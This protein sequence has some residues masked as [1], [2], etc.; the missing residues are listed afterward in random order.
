MVMSETELG[1]PGRRY[2]QPIQACRQEGQTSLFTSLKHKTRHK[3]CKLGAA[4]TFRE[5]L[6]RLLQ[7]LKSWSPKQ[8]SCLCPNTQELPSYN[9][10]E[11]KGKVGYC[12]LP[13]CPAPNTS[14]ERSSPQASN[15]SSWQNMALVKSRYRH[16]L[17]LTD[18]PVLRG[19]F[20]ERLLE[21]QLRMK[22]HSYN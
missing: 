17:L 7:G 19:S 20:K 14:D 6:C 22:T 4:P 8:A 15:S 21:P 3:G 13:G 12:K 11:R 16:Q 10:W 9:T 1:S 18:P 5:C 2:H